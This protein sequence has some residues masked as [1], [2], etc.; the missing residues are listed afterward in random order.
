VNMPDAPNGVCVYG[1][2]AA[3]RHLLPA[4]HRR[5]KL[6][7]VYQMSIGRGEWKL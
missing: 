5:P 1:C 2:D 3:Q 7:R 4:L 6:C